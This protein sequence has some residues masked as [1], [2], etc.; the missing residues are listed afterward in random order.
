M[1]KCVAV[2][3]PYEK[4]RTLNSS[5]KMPTKR[6]K[7]ANSRLYCDECGNETDHELYWTVPGRYMKWA[8]MVVVGKKEYVLICP[9]CGRGHTLTKEQAASLRT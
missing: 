7:N 3:L 6:V 4:E 1:A 5:S 2:D 8:G 9:T